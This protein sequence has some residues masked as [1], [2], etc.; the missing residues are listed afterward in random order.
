MT[1]Y[2]DKLIEDCV[3]N[4]ENPIYFCR[5]ED[6]VTD[7]VAPSKGVLEFLLE[8]ENLEGTNAMELLKAHAAKGKG[9]S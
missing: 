4:K 3:K 6:M 9:A 8:V 7:I 2:F 1:R 5:Y